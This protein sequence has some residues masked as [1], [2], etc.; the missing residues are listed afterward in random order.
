MNQRFTRCDQIP[1]SRIH[2][3][4]QL[5]KVI[6]PGVENPEDP[7]Q[8]QP[9]LSSREMIIFLDNAESVFGPRGTDAQEIYAV[10]EELSLFK[11]VCLCITSRIFTIPPTCESPD[12]PTLSA[13][14]ARDTFYHIYRKWKDRQSM[15]S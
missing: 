10:T 7:T 5:S 4:S 15:I 1:T 9:F 8:L 13:Q 12:V 11:N 2:F 3:L 6:G 14:A